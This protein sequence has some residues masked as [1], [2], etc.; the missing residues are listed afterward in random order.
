MPSQ[1]WTWPPDYKEAEPLASKEASQV[2]GALERVYKPG[3]PLMD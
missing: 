3:Y 1:W 2:V